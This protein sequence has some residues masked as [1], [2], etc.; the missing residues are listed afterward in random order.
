MP[1]WKSL[2]QFSTPQYLRDYIH[3]FPDL[4]V[5]SNK[6]AGA[7]KKAVIDWGGASPAISDID[8]ASEHQFFR[9]RGWVKQFFE[10]TDARDWVLVEE[11]GPYRYRVRLKKA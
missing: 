6:N 10:M 5:G 9:G 8:G 1:T 2:R 11:T 7:S 3:R 4:V